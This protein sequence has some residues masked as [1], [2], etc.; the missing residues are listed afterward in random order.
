MFD[1]VY[2]D[3]M[4]YELYVYICFYVLSREHRCMRGR[5]GGGGGSV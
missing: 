4:F 3:Y 5:R 1:N 2:M